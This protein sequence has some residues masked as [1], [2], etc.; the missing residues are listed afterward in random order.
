MTR[1]F[2]SGCSGLTLTAQER[3]FFHKFQPWGLILFVRNCVD[4]D[5]IRALITDFRECAGSSTAP[6][7][8]DQEGGRV[9]RL[10][11]PHWA[12]YPPGRKFGDAYATQP[13]LACEMAELA[14]I[15]IGSDLYDL[16]INIDCAPVVDVPVPGAHDIIGDR[17]YGTQP[18]QVAKLARA[19]AQGLMRAGVCPVI[20]HIP[21]HGRAL[22]DSHKALPTVKAGV[23]D[24][25][26]QDFAAFKALADLP[27]AMTAHVIYE[28]YDRQYSA[29]QS[30][31]II[32]DVI[33]GEI[34]FDGLL[35]SDD[36]SM[37]ALE[38]SFEER[39]QRAFEAGC[40][41]V[42]HCNGNLA[43]MTSIAQTCPTLA[44]EA[45][46][47]AEKAL[48]MLPKQ[49]EIAHNDLRAKLLKWAKESPIIS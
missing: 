36:L 46:R 24:L 18:E 13:E 3:E 16:G 6:V 12:Q 10:T 11:P 2:I 47:R 39:A 5:Q 28:A 17:A 15:C 38:G 7:L 44:G 23:D 37:H 45:L 48:F 22:A 35:M 30:A 40:D 21:G 14:G 1:A 49:P 41:M 31:T 42:L 26:S 4:P 25:R 9:Q 20:K 34:G 33:R 19:M 8:I 29:T 32:H 27:A 43:E